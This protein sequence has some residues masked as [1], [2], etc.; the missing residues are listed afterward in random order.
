MTKTNLVAVVIASVLSTSSAFAQDVTTTIA[1]ATLNSDDHTT[2]SAA[3]Q[4]AGLTETLQGSGPYTVFAPD[5]NAFSAL[6]TDTVG[7][8]FE[9]DNESD[10]QKVV[11]G[12]IIQG[13]I[14]IADLTAQAAGSADNTVSLRTISGSEILAEVNASGIYLQD[15]YGTVARIKIADLDQTNGVVHVVDTVLVVN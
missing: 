9:L 3:V 11:N 10:L 2:L 12:H 14:S 5:D 4:V 1:D 6:P 8:L 13:E 7:E 15:E